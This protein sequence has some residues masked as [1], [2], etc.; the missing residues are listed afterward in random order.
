MELKHGEVR[1]DVELSQSAV[2]FDRSQPIR[3]LCDVELNK[4]EVRWM[5]LSQSEVTWDVE[6]KQSEGR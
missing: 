6:L 5:E 4:S 2:I 1:W 3:I